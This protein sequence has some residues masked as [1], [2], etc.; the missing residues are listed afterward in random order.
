MALSHRSIRQINLLLWLTTAGV[1]ALAGQKCYGIF[2]K[3]QANEFEL[4]PSGIFIR[5]IEG[6]EDNDG[7][8]R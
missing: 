1:G 8:G 3:L 5:L 4:V 7:C 6:A 2:R